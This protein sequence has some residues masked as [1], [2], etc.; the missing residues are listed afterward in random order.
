MKRNTVRNTVYIIGFWTLTTGLFYGL[1]DLV[2]LIR[3]IW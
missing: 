2:E 3:K 1:I